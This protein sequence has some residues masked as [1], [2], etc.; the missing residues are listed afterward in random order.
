MVYQL[1]VELIGYAEDNK[2]DVKEQKNNT[3]GEKES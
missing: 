3:E 2:Y 1:I